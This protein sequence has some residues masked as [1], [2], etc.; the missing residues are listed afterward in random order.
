MDQEQIEK[1]KLSIQKLEEKTSR[2]YFF[3]H[4]TKGN[5]KASI[6]YIYDMALTLKNNGYNSTILH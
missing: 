4:D 6:K 3:V 2:I 1:V 5:P